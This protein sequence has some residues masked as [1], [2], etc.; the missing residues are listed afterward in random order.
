[1]MAGVPTGSICEFIADAR[2]AYVSGST[3]TSFI[4][5][6]DDAVTH[7]DHKISG[8]VA[9]GDPETWRE[10][11]RLRGGLHMW[12]RSNDLASYLQGLTSKSF[13]FVT[14]TTAQEYT[15]SSNYR[16]GGET[17]SWTSP[18]P[19][20]VAG[21]EFGFMIADS[22]QSALVKAYVENDL[23]D[24]SP[25]APT[26]LSLSNIGRN[27]ITLN[28]TKATADR[29]EV[30]TGSGSWTDI[31]N[32]SQY[33]FTG[34]SAD[35]AY[36]F[37]IRSKN[38]YGTQSAVSAEVTA[39]GRTL[40]A[41][42]PLNPPSA[43][44][45]LS[46]TAT[47]N[48]I[49]LS[50]TAGAGATSS[51]VSL[52]SSTWKS[53]GTA[54][55]NVFEDLSADTSY[56]L[57]VRS[58]N[59]D[60]VSS[61]V[62]TSI[63]TSAT[64]VVGTPTG[65]SATITSSTIV[66]SWSAVTGAT[67]YQV[68]GGALDSW[69]TVNA[70]S[71]TFTSLQPV[72]EY[73]VEVRAVDAN[74]PGAA[75]SLT[76]ETIAA[77]PFPPRGLTSTSTQTSITVSWDA[78][79]DPSF[80]PDRYTLRRSGSNQQFTATGTSYTFSGL[81]P[82]TQY[83]ITVSASNGSGSSSNS[84]IT[85]RTL[86]HGVLPAP[87]GLSVVVGENT[88]QLSWNNVT[89]ATSYQ[90]RRGA[91]AWA[92]RT[93]PHTFSGLTANTEYVLSV[94]SVT[95][96]T[97]YSP[98]TS[99]AA[100]ITRRTLEL[101][102]LAA[103]TGL[104]VSATE[105]SLT[106]T[107]N[108][109]TGA[110]SYDVRQG[111]GG[112]WV[113]TRSRTHT[114]SGLSEDTSYTLFVRAKNSRATSNN[115]AIT[116]STSEPPPIAPT[117]PPPVAPIV[118]PELLALRPR[119]VICQFKTSISVTD[120]RNIFSGDSS[121]GEV[122]DPF[123]PIWLGSNVVD[124]P[125]VT[126]NLYVDGIIWSETAPGHGRSFGI[127]L[128]HTNNQPL[129]NDQNLTGNT[130]FSLYALWNNNIYEYRFNAATKSN[131]MSGSDHIGNEYTWT[132]AARPAAMTGGNLMRVVIARRGQSSLVKDW[133]KSDFTL[134]YNGIN[135]TDLATSNITRAAYSASWTS[136]SFYVDD[137]FFEVRY[138]HRQ[139]ANAPATT[140]SRTNITSFTRSN[141]QENTNY[142]WR[143]R[144]ETVEYI[145]RWSKWQSLDTKPPL[146]ETPAAP[147]LSSG[148]G[149]LEYRLTAP[150]SVQ[151][152]AHYEA[153]YDSASSFASATVIS[154]P[155][156]TGSV[157]GLTNGTRY[158]VRARAVAESGD[159][160]AWSGLS[161]AIPAKPAI[162]MLS[163]TGQSSTT[164]TQLWA[165]IEGLGEGP[166]LPLS[167]KVKRKL[168]KIGEWSMEV[169]LSDK[170]AH[171][172]AQERRV[173][174]H[175]AWHGIQREIAHGIIREITVK[176]SASGPTLSVSGQ[177]I[178]VELKYR[179]VNLAFNNLGLT[180]L[181][182]SLSSEV[183]WSILLDPEQSHRVVNIRYDGSTV[184]SALQGLARYYG[185]H[186]RPYSGR[187]MYVSRLGDNS[188]L[189]L[190]RTEHLSAGAVNNGALML[191]QDIDQQT[192]SHQIFNRIYVQG[193][194]A[195]AAS[196][197]LGQ[198]SRTSPYPIRRIIR[199]GNPVYYIEDQTSIA[200]HGVIEKQVLFKNIQPVS[201]QPS[202]IEAAADL[203]YD[204]AVEY[205]LRYREPV[206]AYG[207]SILSRNRP[208]YPG[209]KIHIDYHADIDG[210]PYMDVKDDFWIMGVDETFDASGPHA[211][212]TIQSIDRPMHSA[213][214]V[215]IGAIE[216]IN[217]SAT[218]PGI[219]TNS[220]VKTIQGTITPG[221]P[222]QTELEITDA[223]LYLQRVRIRLETRP[224][225]AI[226]EEGEDFVIS[227]GSIN[228]ASVRVFIDDVDRTNAM[229]G[230]EP[231]AVFGAP[232]EVRY[233]GAAILG[234]LESAGLYGNHPIR[235]T[236]G[237]GQGEI[238]GSIEVY[239][240]VQSIPLIQRGLTA[241]TGT[242][243]AAPGNPRADQI[244]ASQFRARWNAVATA[245]GY[246]IEILGRADIALTGTSRTISGRAGEVIQWRVA[247]Q[248]GAFT[249]WVI[250][251]LTVT[252][253]VPDAPTL[254]PEDAALHFYINPIPNAHYDVQYKRS[255]GSWSGN[256]TR[257]VHNGGDLTGLT[258]GAQYDVRC[259]SI[260][261][262]ATSGWSGVSQETPARQDDVL[263]YRGETIRYRGEE[264]VI[265]DM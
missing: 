143:V 85:T 198:S 12:T 136:P 225:Q 222:L 216:N 206:V 158:Y 259:R 16:S 140:R 243:L 236:C 110:T 184:M 250:T 163:L 76:R 235:I 20:A 67:S 203:L 111:S 4:W 177:T 61:A 49:T 159:A 195:V 53:V 257:F 68:M 255:S 131:V 164:D 181:I 23:A 36:T 219:S 171:L 44:T 69:T 190:H 147:T 19:N 54:T 102:T 153:Q 130:V 241:S 95:T 239:Q 229:F 197:T 208:I 35:T 172:L 99:S 167:A 2:S 42:T 46:G 199:R 252:A 98:R 104:A 51:E 133:C 45:G 146:P 260:V 56:T 265:E 210:T 15:I 10:L 262:S 168:D 31:G 220:Y 214:E 21:Q 125:E 27:A 152:I 105:D 96:S 178:E 180:T 230:E 218:Q 24:V 247:A 157:L 256:I 179:L 119:D 33:T 116:E 11:S 141:L 47:H 155:F 124:N 169:S 59:N 254:T 201:N 41:V 191:A 65:L 75:T 37:G 185:L 106:L 73:T 38:V 263:R 63:R 227:D 135:A 87:S 103:P 40:R 84:S 231:L 261:G 200:R 39:T 149:F 121:S 193:S 138:Q 7:G 57:Y 160:S 242:T 192:D 173:R 205:L 217:T 72:T 92:T 150:A 174:L 14:G 50:W 196:L 77:R 126:S 139:G 114:F 81:S 209:D 29:Y 26:A 245:S 83:T 176:D 74:G 43:P 52:D 145:S 34:L 137:P 240:V 165:D 212:L 224:L 78:E 86:Q 127:R 28:W 109:V 213:A 204:S 211:N 202:A 166:I 237:S 194:G 6:N 18:K 30:R 97:L 207:T 170:R 3:G 123:H 161:S 70:T 71:Y 108:A 122:P 9:D 175:C 189:R 117:T 248:G 107:W 151:L 58:R 17:V 154:S 32:V 129:V 148:N 8:R 79:D 232:L 82:N 142:S 22:G 89:D 249:D 134:G 93:S 132:A 80:A 128:E 88:L 60:G 188:G 94:R 234:W 90:V 156:L 1:M 186:L 48:A 253:T 233:E 226:V 215:V 13:Y 112:T 115:A 113:N 251:R 183:A 162:P 55:Q 264:L 5:L 223:T 66:L 120:N 182:N 64:P 244:T 258:N 228:P 62:S 91:G 100:S 187:R 246:I 101:S 118:P 221:K 144:I 238:S 25:S